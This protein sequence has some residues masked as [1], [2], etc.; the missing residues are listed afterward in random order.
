M[1]TVGVRGGA[2]MLRRNVYSPRH[3]LVSPLAP[4]R[5]RVAGGVEAVGYDYTVE[6]EK[7]RQLLGKMMETLKVG[8]TGE[9]MI[10]DYHS[11]LRPVC[12][13]DVP[14]IGR[15]AVTNLYINSGHGSKGW[16]YSWG[17]S[18]LLAQVLSSP[19]PHQTL[20]FPFQIICGEHS[21]IDTRRFDPRR[22]HIF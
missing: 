10:L 12:A 6:E 8:L 5:L 15:T 4:G 21:Q 1:V 2:D 16:T 22:F 7:G 3:G 14:M 19:S 20:T 9:D 11:C 13:D 18:V 17:S